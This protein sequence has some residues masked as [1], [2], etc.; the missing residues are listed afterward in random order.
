M[1]E[2]FARFMMGRYGNDRL[3]QCLLTLAMILL[4]LSWFTTDAFYMVAVLILVYAYYRMFSKNT[5]KR[6]AENQRFVQWECK[7]KGKLNKKKK[8]LSQLKTHHIYKCPNCKLA[9]PAAPIWRR[10]R[11]WSVMPHRPPTLLGA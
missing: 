9:P 7:M 5:Y 8:E 4:I 11:R 1:R 6:Y 3:N 10:C 2:K